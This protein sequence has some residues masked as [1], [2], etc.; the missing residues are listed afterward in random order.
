MTRLLKNKTP[1][2]CVATSESC[3]MMDPLLLLSKFSGWNGRIK[4]SKNN[5]MAS[6]SMIL[7]T[8]RKIR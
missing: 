7:A 4:S 1:S 2:S 5:T 6:K 3:H 8:E